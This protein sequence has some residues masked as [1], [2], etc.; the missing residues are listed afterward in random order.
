MIGSDGRL[1]CSFDGSA[2]SSSVWIWRSISRLGLL[3]EQ[4][5]FDGEEGVAAPAWVAS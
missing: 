1:D 3:E 2:S 5:A 4:V